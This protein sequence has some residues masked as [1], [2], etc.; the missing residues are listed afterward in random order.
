[1]TLFNLSVCRVPIN[2]VIDQAINKKK[3][4]NDKIKLVKCRM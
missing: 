1:L 2:L 3:S 4:E